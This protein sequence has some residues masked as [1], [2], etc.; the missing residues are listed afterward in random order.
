MKKIVF[1]YFILP[2][3]RLYRHVFKPKTYGARAVLVFK[4][5]SVLLIKNSGTK[6][7][8]LPGGKIEYGETPKECVVREIREE[9]SIDINVQYLLGEYFSQKEGKRDTVYIYVC[10]TLSESF[11]KNYELDDA[12][13]FKFNDLPE[14]IGSAA[15][16][17][18]NEYRGNQKNIKGIW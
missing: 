17:R 18:I 13:W 7:Y 6:H 10:D 15:S 14:N 16:K 11:S 12:R 9:L 4:Q 3:A 1:T 2:V 8:T 5:E